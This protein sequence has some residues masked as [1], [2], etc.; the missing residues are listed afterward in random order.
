MTKST[1]MFG[2]KIVSPLKRGSNVPPKLNLNEN[3]YRNGGTS[4]NCPDLGLK[5]V[6]SD[7]KMGQI[8]LA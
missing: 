7:F 2:E 3:E 5:I 6:I 8:N 4:G 1:F